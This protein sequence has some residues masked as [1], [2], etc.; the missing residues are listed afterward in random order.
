MAGLVFMV[1]IPCEGYEKL[2]V[3]EVLWDKNKEV[4]QISS[5]EDETNNF[6]NSK[7]SNFWPIFGKI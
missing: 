6:K 3:K 7:V 1:S 2:L 5:D 4:Q